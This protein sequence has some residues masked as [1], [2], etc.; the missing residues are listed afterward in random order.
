MLREFLSHIWSSCRE[1][2]TCIDLLSSQCNM[3]DNARTTRCA[4]KREQVVFIRRRR[5]H[6]TR[7][8]KWFLFNLFE[9]MISIQLIWKNRLHSTHSKK[10]F[11]FILFEQ[12]V[13]IQSSLFFRI[14][15]NSFEKVVIYLINL[16]KSFF[17]QL[18]WKCA[19][20]LTN[21]S[22]S[23][24]TWSK[25]LWHSSLDVNEKFFDLRQACKWKHFS[26]YNSVF[27]S[28]LHSLKNL[29]DILWVWSNFFLEKNFVEY[30]Y[31][32]LCRCW[33]LENN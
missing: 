29:L 30:L 10:S 24:R 11:L 8:K 16:K 25:S 5:F 26:S 28:M 27:V 32:Y 17:I 23:S 13:F 9:K 1:C 6:S 19:S 12:V 3:T 15:F 20:F 22:F 31:I 2:L 21:F 7:L 18:I 4:L 33:I 14:S